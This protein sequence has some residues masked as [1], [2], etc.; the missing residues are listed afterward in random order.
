MCYGLA[1]PV[2][3]VRACNSEREMQWSAYGS[4]R[5]SEIWSTGS[6]S[7]ATNE[8]CVMVRCGVLGLYCEMRVRARVKVVVLIV[9]NCFHK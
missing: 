5:S 9:W 6:R 4:G 2:F 3:R 8:T 7:F 1:A